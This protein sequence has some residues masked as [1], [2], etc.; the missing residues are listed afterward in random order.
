M[1]TQTIRRHTQLWITDWEDEDL[2]DPD[3]R[4]RAT[5]VVVVTKREADEG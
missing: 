4:K 3:E 1:Q 5:S 2:W